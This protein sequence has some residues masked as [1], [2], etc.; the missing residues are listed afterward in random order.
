MQPDH[1]RIVPPPPLHRPAPPRP[2]LI[3]TRQKKLQH[4]LKRDET[5]GHNQQNGPGQR[6][7][8]VPGTT[9]LKPPLLTLVSNGKTRA[10]PRSRGQGS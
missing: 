9:N 6:A 8:L 7:P 2:F 10:P 5:N 1:K 4:P 3:T